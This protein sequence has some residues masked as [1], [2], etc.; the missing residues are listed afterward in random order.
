MIKIYNILLNHFRPQGWWPTVNQKTGRCEYHKNNY[1]IPQTEQEKLQVILGAILTQNTSW[2]NVEK[3]IISLSKNKLIDVDK[4][5]S[6]SQKKLAGIIRSSGYYNQ[7]SERLKIFCDYLI[8]NYNGNISRF[9]D[10]KITDLREELL[11]IKGIGPETADSIIL[12]AAQKPI[13]V[14]DAYTKRIFSRLGFC[15]KDVSYDELQKLAHSKLNKEVKLFN[16][17]HALIVELGKD[18]C[19]RKPLCINCPVNNLCK[20]RS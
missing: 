1:K 17:F 14:V 2:S 10:K 9:F 8:K 13:F 6:I 19:K 5:S 7:K 18:F 15:N 3:A 12:Y 4:I 20:K 16:E 11:S